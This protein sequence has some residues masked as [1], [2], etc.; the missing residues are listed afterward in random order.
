M[1]AF[2]F[3]FSIKGVS[4]CQ[5]LQCV[6]SPACPSI[7]FTMFQCHSESALIPQGR[8]LS[9]GARQCCSSLTNRVFFTCKIERLCAG[10]CSCLYLLVCEPACAVGCAI[11][12]S[13][14]L[15]LIAMHQRPCQWCLLM[16]FRFN[17]YIIM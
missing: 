17:F 8:L 11:V 2:I 12:P 13:L 1:Y 15:C 7:L 4:C 14:R 16:G 9:A 5:C 10:T 6:D 3:K